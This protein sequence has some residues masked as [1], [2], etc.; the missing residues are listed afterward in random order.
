MLDRDEWKAAARLG[1]AVR[2]TEWPVSTVSEALTLRVY[3]CLAA[4]RTASEAHDQLLKPHLTH[5]C[6]RPS[7]L[8]HVESLLNQTA[9]IHCD[10][11]EPHQQPTQRSTANRN[12]VLP[13]RHQYVH[14][15][16]EESKNT[17]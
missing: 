7:P 15:E 14:A 12:H 8:D 16:I 5:D 11:E 9:A 17:Y 1:G 2:A 13:I 3:S 4:L 6:Q 10:S